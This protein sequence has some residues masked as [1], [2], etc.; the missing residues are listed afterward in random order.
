[1]ERYTESHEGGRAFIADGMEVKRKADIPMSA[2]WTPNNVG[3]IINTGYKADVRESASVAHIY[4]QELVAVESMTSYGSPWAWSPEFLKPTAD[5]ELACGANRFVQSV[6]VH[7]P[8][9]DKLPGLSLGPY[10]PWLNRHETWAEQAQPWMT[11]LSRSSYMLQQGENV[12]DIIYYYGDDS[13]ITALF[14]NQL[15]DIPPGY[16]YDFVNSDALL[17]I[18]SSGRGLIV[19]PDGMTYKLLALDH[20]CR[21]MT[22]PVLKKIDAMV[23]SGAV[24]VGDKPVMTPSLADDQN[25]FMALVSELWPNEKGENICGKGKVYAGYSISEVLGLLKITPDF[26]YARTPDD[27]ELLFV[28]HKLNDIDIY[29]INNRSSRS[30]EVIATFRVNKRAPEIWHPET[31]EIEDA[32]YGIS[33]GRTE[34][35]LRLEPEDAIFIVFRKNAAKTSLTVAQP[36]ETRLA[37]IDGQWDL[38]FQP[39]R[40][41]PSGIVADKL[42]TWSE[43]SD[44]GIKYF[45]GTGSYSKVI[46][47][48]DAWF[49]EEQ[50]I[51]LDLGDVKN[52]AEVMVNGK[53]LGIVWKKPFR[54]NLTGQIKQGKNTLEV[55]I[56]NLWV[57]RLIGDQQPG[58]T[59]KITYTSS[60]FY[61]AGSPLLPAGLIGPVVITGLSKN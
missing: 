37:V 34:M 12:A 32:S 4:G 53:S 21:Y 22:L 45:S 1:M 7:S 40:G 8:S 24:V 44:P 30:E 2:L 59:K 5:M 39:D 54:V 55:K 35:P 52:L 28:H 27:T 9:E 18:L 38:K 15:P 29:W 42:A 3:G 11:Y 43:N 23:K 20:N 47:A 41:A 36:V 31:G 19:T 49:K 33:Y 6:S 16:N 60:A 46:Q 51:W 57:N 58:V 61:S 26:S 10:G 14:A 17:N 25:E 56:T 48:P 13:N 50:Q